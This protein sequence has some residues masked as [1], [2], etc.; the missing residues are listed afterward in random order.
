MQV[1]ESRMLAHLSVTFMKNVMQVSESRMLAH[2]S[3]TFIKSVM[4]VIQRCMHLSNIV[5][6]DMQFTKMFGPGC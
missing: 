3:V 5:E 6:S 4:Q 1:S 2:L